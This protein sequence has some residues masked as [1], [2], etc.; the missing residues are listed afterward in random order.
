[1]NFMRKVWC[2]VLSWEALDKRNIRAIKNV[3]GNRCFKRT[4]IHCPH[5][6]GA[7]GVNSG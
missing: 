4:L 1:M 6:A 2:P 3:R 7:K 5:H